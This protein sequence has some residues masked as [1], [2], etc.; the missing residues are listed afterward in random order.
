MVRFV[1][2]YAWRTAGPQQDAGTGT[3]EQPDILSFEY[4]YMLVSRAQTMPFAS[5]FEEMDGVA[6]GKRNAFLETDDATVLNKLVEVLKTNL[7]RGLPLPAK[8]SAFRQKAGVPNAAG[9]A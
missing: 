3:T 4:P 7:L 9:P 1:A 5:P 6:P 2:S 8:Y